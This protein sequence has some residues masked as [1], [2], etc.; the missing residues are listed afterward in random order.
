MADVMFILLA[1]GF[2]AASI[3]LVHVFERL[4]GQK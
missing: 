2:I 3:G 1:V 4:R